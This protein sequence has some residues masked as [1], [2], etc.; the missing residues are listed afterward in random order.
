VS[1][2]IRSGDVAQS[3]LDSF[4]YLVV[5]SAER[6]YIGEVAPFLVGGKSI[7]GLRHKTTIIG[8]STSEEYE[9]QNEFMG[10]AGNSSA[11]YYYRVIAE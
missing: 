9:R 8:E 5:A 1:V 4:G 10:I 6:W 3:V 11:P 7:T 2:K